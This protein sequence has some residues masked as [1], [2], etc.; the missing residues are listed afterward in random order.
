M[1]EPPARPRR[2]STGAAGSDAGPHGGW[3]GTV[4]R[5]AGIVVTLGAIWSLL[6]I[7][8]GGLRWAEWV[9]N[10]F[11]LI[12]VPTAPTLFSAALLS[13]L[14]SAL[15]RRLR[16][17]LIVAVVLEV[18]NLTTYVV[19]LAA[20]SS[21]S[22]VPGRIES[23]RTTAIAIAAAVSALVVVL[24]IASRREFPA[25]LRPGS[26]RLA[27]AVLAGG[28][29]LAAGA[30]LAI[31]A[32]FPHGLYGVDERVD[33]ALD[34]ALGFSVPGLRHPSLGPGWGHFLVSSFSLLVLLAELLTVFVNV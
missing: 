4:A 33:W 11:L 19:A 7:A 22:R 28:L 1:T 25:R 5:I 29:T 31:A 13:L 2:I 3:R 10:A 32:A 15:R 20:G 14:G 23:T 26:R 16:A 18:V 30:G 34:A 6:S 12:G 17:A 21:I 27:L 24:L 8:V 9:E